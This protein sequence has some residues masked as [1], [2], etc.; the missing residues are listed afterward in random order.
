V[1]G[2]FDSY[3]EEFFPILLSFREKGWNV[4][5]FEG[6][7]QGAVRRPSPIVVVAGCITQ[8]VPIDK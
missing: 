3:I 1:F 6:P 7:G 2:G 5:A 8:R 4:V